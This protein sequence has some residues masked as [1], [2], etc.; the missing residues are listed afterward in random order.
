MAPPPSTTAKPAFGIQKGGE[1]TG[2]SAGA[3]AEG[4]KAK[5][6]RGKVAL[7]PGYSALDWNRLSSSGKNLRGTAGFPL[8]VTMDE[9]KKV[10]LELIS[11]DYGAD[12]RLA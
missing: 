10:R 2:L 7:G 1:D 12:E 4:T 8:R 9:L 11:E 3:G 6:K 5:G